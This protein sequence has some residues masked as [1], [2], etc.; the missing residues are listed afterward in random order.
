[1][2]TSLMRG[3]PSLETCVKGPVW[4]PGEASSSGTPSSSSSP[5][6]DRMVALRRLAYAHIPTT[7]P[8]SEAYVGLEP[9]RVS[10]LFETCI[11]IDWTLNPF[12]ASTLREAGVAIMDTL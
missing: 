6:P 12:V 1:M 11:A 10:E 7:E 4:N 8:L 9:L 2:I 5:S 3:I